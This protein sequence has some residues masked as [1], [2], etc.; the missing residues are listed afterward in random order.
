MVEIP[1]NLLLGCLR[2]DDSCWQELIQLTGGHLQRIA[3]VNLRDPSFAEDVLQE[4]YYKVFRNLHN[5]RDRS[6]AMP[7]IVQILVNECR[8]L[9]RKTKKETTNENEESLSYTLAANPSNRGRD[10]TR[11]VLSGLLRQ[12]PELYR[13][14]LVLREVEGMDYTEIAAALKVPVGTVRSRLAR[15][16][17]MWVELA[18]QS[19][20]EGQL[21]DLYYEGGESVA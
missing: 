6:R 2:G 8:M 13:E 9:N 12:L 4:T 5:L 1:S 16:R 7:W 11:Q 18:E 21:L 20:E 19:V 3:R 17:A 10:E 14:I 15:A